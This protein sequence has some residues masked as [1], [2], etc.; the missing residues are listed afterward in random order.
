[1]NGHPEMTIITTGLVEALQTVQGLS[2][3]RLAAV[4][5]TAS[6]RTAVLVREAERAAMRQVFDRPTPYTLNSIFVKPATAQ[7]PVA[8]VYV[9]DDRA[10]SGT[11][12]TKYLLPQVEGGA[13]RFKKLEGALLAVGAM[14]SGWYI[15]P[16]AGARLDA[17][18]NVSPGQ[19]IQILSQLR[20]TMVSGFTRNMSFNKTKEIAAQRKAGGRFYVRPVGKPKPGIY[21]REF[22]GRNTTPVFTFVKAVRYRPRFDFDGTARRVAEAELGPQYARALAESIAR[23]DGGTALA[24]RG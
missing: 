5:A 24:V 4:K 1:M 18:G 16:G 15:V 22:I 9:K 21:Q 2:E 7:S 20:I 12:A 10:G 14:P 19:V 8:E 11:P 23:R 6:T 3:R 17:Y 13:R